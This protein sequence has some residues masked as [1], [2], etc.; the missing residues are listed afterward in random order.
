M[1]LYTTKMRMNNDLPFVLEI[2]WYQMWREGFG[3]EESLWFCFCFQYGSGERTVLALPISIF[4]AVLSRSLE[5][6][7][8]EVRSLDVF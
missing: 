2:L 1:V 4:M 5:N 8:R 6:L 3:I 7:A